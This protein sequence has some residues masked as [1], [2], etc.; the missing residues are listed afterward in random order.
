MKN[1]EILDIK[2]FMQLLFQTETFDTYLFVS[3][4]IKTDINYQLDGTLNTTYYTEDE[5]LSLGIDN[6]AYQTWKNIKEKIFYIIKGKKTPSQLHIVLRLSDEHAKQ[7][8]GTINSSLNP[9]DIDALF[10]NILFN[11]QKL[12]V[13][14]GISYKIFA[15][16]HD[17]E[18]EFCDNFITL[19]KS[20]K[21]S[22]I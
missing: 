19:F 5:R 16:N 17:L 12:N 6:S 2:L 14:C 21:I 11:E 9:N 18:N 10:L 15:I 1:I 20:Y 4:K 3:S 8:I 22:C 13:T 7:I